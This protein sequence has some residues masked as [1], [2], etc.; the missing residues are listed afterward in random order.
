M[1]VIR[2]L[3]NNKSSG[4]HMILAE[5]IKYGGRV[6]YEEIYQLVAV[7]WNKEEMPS[8]WSKGII[9]PIHKK[10]SK[11]EFENY[12]GISLLSVVFKILATCIKYRIVA[13]IKSSIGEYQRGFR[14]GRSV[15]DQIFALR[16]I[17]AESYDN[18]LKTHV[19]FVDFKQAYD[20]VNIEQVYQ[21]MKVIGVESKLIRL[22][23]MTLS[24]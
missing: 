15:I 20:K 24:K 22:V 14:E 18:K 21:S 3:K 17:Q 9:I 1:E 23:R 4:E 16:E 19:M 10:G 6:I 8:E 13:Q 11:S 12:R 7:V 2:R 5:F